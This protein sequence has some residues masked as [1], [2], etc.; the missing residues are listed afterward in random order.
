MTSV[1]SEADDKSMEDAGFEH[2][3]YVA[4]LD[5]VTCPICGSV[6][7]KVFPIKESEAGDNAPPMHYNCRC[8]KVVVFTDEKLKRSTRIARDENG[9][10]IKVPADMDYAEYKEKYL[11][12]PVDNLKMGQHAPKIETTGTTPTTSTTT[13]SDFKSVFDNVENHEQL[14]KEMNDT[15]GVGLVGDLKPY[16]LDTMKNAAKEMDW[17]VQEFDIKGEVETFISADLGEDTPARTSFPHGG[18]SGDRVIEI[19]FDQNCYKPENIK[20][21]EEMVAEAKTSRY[22][23]SGTTAGVMDH[24]MGHVLLNVYVKR[25]YPRDAVSQKVMRKT[26]ASN[27]VNEAV[28]EVQKIPKYSKWTKEQILTELSGRAAENDFE[29]LAEA[30]SDWRAHGMGAKPFSKE[31]INIF[32]RLI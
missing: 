12:N 24:E 28:R 16:D 29:A 2:Y 26:V 7:N 6:D 8:R 5:E 1:T 32:R 31:V 18:G 13:T 4:T 11:D 22:L 14:M 30:S 3:R 21:F 15:L 17:F 20:E 25:T 10:P 23:V 9:D 19:E 27:V